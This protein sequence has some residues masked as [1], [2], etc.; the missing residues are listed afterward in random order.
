MSA[1]TFLARR[2]RHAL[3]ASA[4]ALSIAVAA[5]FV[6]AVSA[7]ATPADMSAR[8]ASGPAA[9]RS[10]TETDLLRFVWVAD[11]R[12][13]PDGSRVVFVR[14]T[15]DEGEKGYDTALWIV[16]ADGSEPA[17]Q[18]TSGRRDQSPR[19]SPDGRWIAFTRAAEKEDGKGEFEP[20][21]L[22]LIPAGGGEAARLTDLPKDAG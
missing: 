22:H 9:R 10:I 13:S 8:A 15:V 1:S 3:P 21:Q 20:A 4:A 18:F 2:A 6:L 11:P 17:R 5:T 12:I 14:V 16:P 7:L 19:W